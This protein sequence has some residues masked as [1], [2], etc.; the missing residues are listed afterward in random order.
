MGGFISVQLPRGW[1]VGAGV[2]T[3]WRHTVP[4]CGRLPY[5]GHRKASEQTPY[6][7]VVWEFRTPSVPKG[8]ACQPSFA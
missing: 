6:K 5:R 2:L 1:L 4:C 8:D 7:V 3:G